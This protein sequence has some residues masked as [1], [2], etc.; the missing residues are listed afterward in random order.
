MILTD[1]YAVTFRLGALRV[2]PG[3]TF[4]GNVCHTA[5]MIIGLLLIGVAAGLGLWGAMRLAAANPVTRLPFWGWPPNRPF[6]ARSLNV[7]MMMV[8][9]FGTT[10][11][12]KDGS[13]PSELWELPGFLLVLVAVLVPGI[14]HNRKV[15]RTI[16]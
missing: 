15:A 9:I 10:R 2:A 4:T 14:I 6:G 1:L 13:H 11:L 5:P 7:L 12:L 8:A 3:L 16:N